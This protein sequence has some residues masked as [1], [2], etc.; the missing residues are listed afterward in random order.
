MEYR[1][2]AS[3]RA[4]MDLLAAVGQSVR[5]ARGTGPDCRHWHLGSAGSAAHVGVFA[6][7]CERDG[8]AGDSGAT[9]IDREIFGPQAPAG[10][11]SRS[12]FAVVCGRG[13]PHGPDSSHVDSHRHPAALLDRLSAYLA[14]SGPAG[15]AVC[16]RGL[17]LRFIAGPVAGGGREVARKGNR[18]RARAETGCG[19]AVAV[20]RVTPPSP[21][22]VQHTQF[23][24]LAHSD[25]SRQGGTDRGT[26]RWPAALIAG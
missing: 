25:G 26:A 5:A 15:S 19:G 16:S 24:Q 4:R 12:R 2:D 17:L 3:N 21:L 8:A 10:T 11:R 18:G 23:D 9:G 7:L 20:A 1:R 6:G 22:P 13:M 14:G